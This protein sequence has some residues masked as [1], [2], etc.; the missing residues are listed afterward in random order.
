MHPDDRRE[1]ECRGDRKDECVSVGIRISASETNRQHYPD[2]GY[3]AGDKRERTRL[4]CRK[5][6]H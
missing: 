6:E 2:E 3:Q 4:S 5:P 1:E